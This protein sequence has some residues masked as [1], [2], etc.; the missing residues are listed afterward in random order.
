MAHLTEDGLTVDALLGSADDVLTSVALEDIYQT[1]VRDH[2]SLDVIVRCLLERLE[3]HLMADVI[4]D[5]LE[6][7]SR[8]TVETVDLVTPL[9]VLLYIM[10]W[11]IEATSVFL[12]VLTFYLN[13]RE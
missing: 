13:H 4:F 8:F 7:K 9:L 6:V 11:S 5:G 1:L 2:V 10:I 3:Y 12:S